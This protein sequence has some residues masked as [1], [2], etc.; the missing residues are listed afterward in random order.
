MARAQVSLGLKAEV[1]VD[2]VSVFLWCWE[3][4]QGVLHASHALRP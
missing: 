2:F 4:N 3:W 1:M